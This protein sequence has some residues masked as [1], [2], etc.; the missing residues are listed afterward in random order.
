MRAITAKVTVPG[1]ILALG[2]WLAS[3]GRIDETIT[4]LHSAIPALPNAASNAFNGETLL[5]AEPLVTKK[6]FGRNPPCI[7]RGTSN[8]PRLFL[9]TQKFGPFFY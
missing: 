1:V 3:G 6:L 8:S 5:V 9:L 7:V 2:T 4:R